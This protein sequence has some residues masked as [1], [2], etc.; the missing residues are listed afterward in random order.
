L[1]VASGAHV[2]LLATCVTLVLG[3]A[4]SS[5]LK[6]YVTCFSET[7]VGFQRTTWHYISE[8]RNLHNHCCENLKF[9]KTTYTDYSYAHTTHHPY[10]SHTYFMVKTRVLKIFNFI[11]VNLGVVISFHIILIICRLKVHCC[12]H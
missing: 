5:T 10:N 1:K 7:S 11:F 12:E 6:I 4:Y 2:A 8:D 3:L 9:Y